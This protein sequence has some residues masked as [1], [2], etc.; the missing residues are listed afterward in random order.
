MED[1]L[2]VGVI[3]STHGIR[4][5]VK[6]YSTTDSLER[7]LQLED[8]ILVTPRGERLALRVEGVK[9]F[10]QFAILKFEGIDRIEDIQACKGGDLMVTRENAQ[11]L[12]EREYYIGDLIGL[13]VVGDDGREL[14]TI[15]D[16]LQT[17]ANDVY[18][19]SRPDGKE[20]LLPVIDDCILDVNLEQGEVRAHLMEGLLDL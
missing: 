13:R 8:V 2:R 11:P 9:F 10:K 12:G 15:A 3:A 16:V 4:G 19:V 5:E 20:L 1:L 14:G 17:G 7:F 6:V 18:V